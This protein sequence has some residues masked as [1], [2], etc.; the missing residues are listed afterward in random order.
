MPQEWPTF[1]QNFHLCYLLPCP[2]ILLVLLC[3][4][5]QVL[6]RLLYPL[7]LCFNGSFLTPDRPLPCLSRR[8]AWDSM[9][10]IDRESHVV[11]NIIW[12]YITCLMAS[13]CDIYWCLNCCL[14]CQNMLMCAWIRQGYHASQR[15]IQASRPNSFSYEHY[16]RSGLDGLKQ[17]QMCHYRRS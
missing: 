17:L 14:A 11:A 15:K 6:Q 5:L 2:C 7:K 10:K 16:I 9:I 12:A 1:V 13:P 4:S 8:A 3:M